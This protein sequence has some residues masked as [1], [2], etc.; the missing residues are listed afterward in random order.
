MDGSLTQASI[1]NDDRIVGVN[2]N[3][4][5]YG[6]QVTGAWT[7]LYGSLSQVDTKGGINVGVSN[8]GQ[9]S[10]QYGGPI[11]KATNGDNWSQMPGAA[12][13]NSVGADGEVWCVNKVGNI[14]RWNGT[15]D[16]IMIPGGAI[17]V[18]VG[19]AQNVFVV[20]FSDGGKLWKYEGSS[21]KNIPVPVP[22]KYVSV[23]EGG[24]RLAAMGVDGN[25]Y[26]SADKGGTWSQI[27]GNFDGNVSINDNYIVAVNRSNETIYIRKL[28]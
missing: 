12:V 4:E 11:Y 1:G 26:A 5:T 21:F 19:D 9:Y 10:G 23:S 22:I 28:T 2:I 3:Y 27:P 16:W 6:R 20:G 18:S 17:M 14:Y 25:I 13:C 24:T 15:N 8:M 7:N